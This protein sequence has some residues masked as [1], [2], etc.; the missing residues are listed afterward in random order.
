MIVDINK[1]K[2]NPKNPRIIKDYKFKKLVKSVKEFPEMLEKR[3]IVVDENM[4]VLGGNMRLKACHEAGFTT[5]HI[6]KA[7][8]WSDKQKEEF[9]I[10]DN[11]GFGEWDWD[12]LA[13]EWDNIIL[14]DWGVDNFD[15]FE[16]DYNNQEIDI[17]ALEDS[18][19]LKL[20]Y[21]EEEYNF[22][23]EK[24]KKININIEKG[25]LELLN[26]EKV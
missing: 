15:F 18:M 10:K 26:Y 3:P 19:I 17:N 1:V 4:I 23:K 7:E 11:V 22:V 6:L 20:N 2:Y 8:N 16:K 21:N 5:V 9:I 14:S 13:N 25:L 24:L 12:I